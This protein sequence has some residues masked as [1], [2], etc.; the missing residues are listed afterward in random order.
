ML[1]IRKI[2]DDD[3]ESVLGIAVKAFTPI[4]ESFKSLM[5]HNIFQMV[6]PN[7]IESQNNYI[8]ELFLDCNKDNFFVAERNGNIVGFISLLIEEGKDK[9]EIGINAILPEYFRQGIGTQMYKFALNY[10]KDKGVKLVEVST[11]GDDSHIAAR[12]AYIKA[13]FTTSLPLVKFYKKL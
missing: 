12:N 4:H 1:E 5:G 2:K 11:G 8:R 6:Y 3:L 10:M 7:W 13:G 9:A